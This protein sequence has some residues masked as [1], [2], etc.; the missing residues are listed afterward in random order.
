MIGFCPLRSITGKRDK[1]YKIRKTETFDNEIAAAVC[2][3]RPLQEQKGEGVM[4]K[5]WLAPIGQESRQ[6][7]RG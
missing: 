3:L 7:L 4:E 5:L 1:E 2:F 6:G